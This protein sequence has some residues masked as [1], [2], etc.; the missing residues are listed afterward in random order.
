MTLSRS[1]QE[2]WTDG[3]SAVVVT[4]ESSIMLQ[5]VADLG[6]PDESPVNLS[7]KRYALAL[8]GDELVTYL[9]WRN[10]HHA[11]ASGANNSDAY[12]SG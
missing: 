6:L 3:K 4:A 1:L 8:W 12:G 5:L 2:H 10:D 7:C 9:D 11:Y